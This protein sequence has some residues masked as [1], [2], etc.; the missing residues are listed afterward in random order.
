MASSAVFIQVSRFLSWSTASPD[1]ETGAYLLLYALT[2]N[3]I[4]A[5]NHQLFISCSSCWPTFHTGT[6]MGRLV[7]IPQHRPISGQG[8]WP[9]GLSTTT[10]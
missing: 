1:L 7:P 4:V 10:P 5:D 6:N 2:G 8:R 9:Y 3:V